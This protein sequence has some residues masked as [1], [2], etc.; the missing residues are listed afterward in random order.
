MA[1][2]ALPVVSCSGITIAQQPLGQ[3]HCKSMTTKL[4]VH[5]TI[6][7]NFRVVALFFVGRGT[8]IIMSIH[9]HSE[10]YILI[11]TTN[12][13]R[14]ISYL[15]MKQ[16]IFDKILCTLQSINRCIKYNNQLIIRQSSILGKV[17]NSLPPNCEV[18]VQLALF[19]ILLKQQRRDFPHISQWYMLWYSKYSKN[20]S[21]VLNLERPS[22]MISFVLI[23]TWMIYPGASR[24]R[25]SIDGMM[26]IILEVSTIFN[27]PS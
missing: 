22:W 12:Q 15:V 9:H 27:W 6:P 8:I 7:F 13:I 24:R 20:G 25:P 16:L 21:Q 23:A 3:I 2:A 14:T 19:P 10:A 26:D 11:I 1:A 5:S 4:I 17:I 18:V